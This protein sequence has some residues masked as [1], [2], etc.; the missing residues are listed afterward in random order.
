M[1]ACE[2]SRVRCGAA[3]CYAH[4]QAKQNTT[5]NS[6]PAH[7]RQP[8]VATQRALGSNAVGIR[9]AASLCLSDTYR[10]M[11]IASAPKRRRGRRRRRRPTVMRMRSGVMDLMVVRGRSIALEVRRREHLW[12]HSGRRGMRARASCL[13]VEITH[14]RSEVPV[15]RRV[16]TTPQV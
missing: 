13:G 14:H 12:Q 1:S 4:A 5:A 7:E 10:T 8:H 2:L 11:S 15:S 9:A 3:R 6:R 16:G